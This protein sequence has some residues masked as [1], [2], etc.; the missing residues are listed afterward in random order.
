MNEYELLMQLYSF[1]KKH[2]KAINY[3]LEL[4]CQQDTT[5][6]EQTKYLKK[7]VDIIKTHH[8]EGHMWSKIIIEAYETLTTFSN[9]PLQQILSSAFHNYASSRSQTAL[10]SNPNKIIDMFQIDPKLAYHAY[11]EF[12]AVHSRW[13]AINEMYLHQLQLSSSRASISRLLSFNKGNKH[14]SVAELEELIPS[15]YKSDFSVNYDV[16]LSILNNHGAPEENIIKF[17]KLVP[18]TVIDIGTRF[19]L[20]IDFQLFHYAYALTSELEKPKL[21][22]NHIL[23]T[24]RQLPRT[25]RQQTLMNTMQQFVDSQSYY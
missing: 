2:M 10:I 24:L 9:V 15:I 23:L 19:Q 6:V 11:L 17:V 5:A 7:C 4:A 25:E 1:R 16:Y 22:A 21:A 13:E 18:D 3:C 20:A 8:Y 14:E 12:L